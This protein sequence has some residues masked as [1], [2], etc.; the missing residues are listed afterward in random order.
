MNRISIVTAVG[1]CML[2]ACLLGGCAK[3]EAEK[4]SA[5]N[6]STTEKP[7]VPTPS[8]KPEKEEA[9][10]DLTDL[11]LD[12]NVEIGT[13]ELTPSDFLQTDAQ[14]GDLT[15]VSSLTTAELHTSNVYLVPLEY[16]H[17]PVTAKVHVIDTTPPVF[18]GL[19]SITINRG[20]SISYKKGVTVTDNSGEEI[21]YE[22]DNS[23]V[24]VNVCGAYNISY[25]ASDAAGNTV[26][27]WITVT[28]LE[29]TAKV[30]ESTVLPM[31]DEIIAA[32]TTPEMTKYDQ[33]Y[34]LWKW[35][36]NHIKY[37]SYSKYPDYW[38][39]INEG[40]TS[41]KG[42]CYVF[43]AIYSALLTRCEIDTLCVKRTEGKTNHY[44]NLVN[45]GNGWYHCD[46]SP[47]P[48][49]D[50]YKCFMQTDEQL[51]EYTAAFDVYGSSNYY[52]FDPE[53]YP[54]RNTEII[55]PNDISKS[56]KH[57]ENS[58]Q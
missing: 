49:G 11:L 32:V 16:K 53:L 47:R 30:N 18:E 15:I 39:A 28:V 45:V 1:I 13:A 56:L 22:I 48:R 14:D 35:V 43:Y 4:A 23:S 25:S 7:A 42:D 37:S 12:I 8:P 54:E 57:Y 36:G 46:S 40:L 58:L 21:H 52:T 6:I 9:K 29:P 33:A 38:E 34:Q 20:D 27:E 51:A 41:K 3:E 50:P 5:E 44:W 31:L 24:D 2:G 10:P 19:K 55:F 17:C 26:T